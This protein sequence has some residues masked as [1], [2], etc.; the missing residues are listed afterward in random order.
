MKRAPASVG[1]RLKFSTAVR[2]RK[3]RTEDGELCAHLAA[4]A[5]SRFAWS[6][7]QSPPTSEPRGSR[8]LCPPQS[9]SARRSGRTCA[10]NARTARAFDSY[11]WIVSDMCR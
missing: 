6:V 10:H 2:Y 9:Y 11:L 1:E 7:L 4:A 8:R 5:A 3:R